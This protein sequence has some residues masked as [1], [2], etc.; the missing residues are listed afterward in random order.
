[1]PQM[2]DN[3]TSCYDLSHVQQGMLFHSLSG[4]N[5]GIYLQQFVCD[6][7]N[8]LIPSWKLGMFSLIN[9]RFF[10]P[11]F[12]GIAQMGRSSRSRLAWNCHIGTLIGG[13]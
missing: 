4:L 1:M 6:F 11:A 9:T 13:N 2:M 12:C 5:L 7:G 3:R 8:Y 10:E